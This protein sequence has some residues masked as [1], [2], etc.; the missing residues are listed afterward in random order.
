[1]AENTSRAKTSRNRS[2]YAYPLLQVSNISYVYIIRLE[3]NEVSTNGP[4]KT[5]QNN[6][7]ILKMKRT[8]ELRMIV[9]NTL[10]MKKRLPQPVI[11]KTVVMNIL[12]MMK[13]TSK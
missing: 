9:M 4:R 13:R 8:K 10:Q 5:I 1:M 11:P 12:Q 7:N 2:G 6:S 3:S